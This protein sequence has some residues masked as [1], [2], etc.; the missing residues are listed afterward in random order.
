M[1]R[2][3]EWIIE[4]IGWFRIFLSPFLIGLAIGATIYLSNPTAT[5][6]AIALSLFA[7]GVIIGVLWASKIWNKKEGTMWFLSKVMASP[8]LDSIESENKETESELKNQVHQP[9]QG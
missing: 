4:A 5:K 2:L 9:K 3:F 1:F 6:F 8:D 7:L